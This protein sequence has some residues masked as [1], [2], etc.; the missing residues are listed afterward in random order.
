M[1]LN[2][3]DD[4]G[5]RIGSLRSGIHALSETAG[6]WTAFELNADIAETVNGKPVNAL[7]V[8]VIVESSAAEVSVDDVQLLQADPSSIVRNAS[9]ESMAAATSSSSTNSC[10]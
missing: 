10:A 7:K 6:S 2:L 5:K 9:F 8:V 4:Q 3:L 1:G